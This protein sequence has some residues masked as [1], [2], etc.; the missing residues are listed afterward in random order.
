[1]SHWI[2]VWLYGN[3]IALDLT[4]RLETSQIARFIWPRWGPP[5]S[6]R[7]RV[8]P[9]LAPWTLLTGIASFLKTLDIF[10]AMSNGKKMSNAKCI[11]YTCWTHHTY[12]KTLGV[13]VSDLSSLSQHFQTNSMINHDCNIGVKDFHKFNTVS[14]FFAL[15]VHAMS[16]NTHFNQ[17]F[18]AWNISP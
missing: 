16:S 6:D 1:M 8:G 4:I 5:G 3:I 7:A 13:W 12:S 15:L 18:W 10:Q 11:D 14:T 17:P 9:M 2:T